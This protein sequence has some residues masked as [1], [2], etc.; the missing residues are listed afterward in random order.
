M[1]Q[2]K[3]VDPTSLQRHQQQRTWQ[4]L[5]P[6][7]AL[8]VLIL[9]AAVLLVAGGKNQ[10]RN[11]ADISTIWLLIPL[12]ILFLLFA[13]LLGCGI[14]GLARLMRATPHLTGRVQ[15]FSR[16]V[17]AGSRKAADGITRPVT[18]LQQAGA[19]LQVIFGK[20]AGR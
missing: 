3:P 5:V 16:Q 9:A 11:W 4:I 1:A 7:F 17:A 8:S 14:Y 12:L 18:W 20:L 10:V 6:F 13:V 2:P 15:E 19:V